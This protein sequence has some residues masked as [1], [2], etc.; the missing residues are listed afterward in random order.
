MSPTARM[1]PFLIAAGI[2]AALVLPLAVLTRMTSACLPGLIDFNA[3]IEL[4]LFGLAPAIAAGVCLPPQHPV[5]RRLLWLWILAIAL[6]LPDGPGV[7]PDIVEAGFILTLALTIARGR[8]NHDSRLIRMGIPLA[9]LGLAAAAI[10]TAIGAG[11]HDAPLRQDARLVGGVAALSLGAMLW[12]DKIAGCR[13][14]IP[15]WRPWKALKPIGHPAIV[16]IAGGGLLRLAAPYDPMLLTLAAA[17]WLSGFI[18][19]ALTRLGPIK[20]LR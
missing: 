11:L 17:F 18:I 20:A 16:L 13:S 7:L 6:L 8:I 12:L 4:I 19:L 14:G 2:V 1:H 9:L 10:A 3:D 15:D 5:T